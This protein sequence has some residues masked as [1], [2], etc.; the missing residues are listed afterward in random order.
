MVAETLR[1][2]RRERV[3]ASLDGQLLD[4]LRV[5]LP[6]GMDFSRYLEDYL[7]AGVRALRPDLS[8]YAAYRRQRLAEAS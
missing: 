2:P 7:R 5:T 6:A 4:D 8:D 1:R 3:S